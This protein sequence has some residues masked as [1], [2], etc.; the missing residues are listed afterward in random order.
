MTKIRET[1]LFS[2]RT[3]YRYVFYFFIQHALVTNRQ[4]TLRSSCDFIFYTL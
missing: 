1:C 3:R 2:K 4:N